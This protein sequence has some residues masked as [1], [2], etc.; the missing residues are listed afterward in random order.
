TAPGLVWFHGGGWVL[1]SLASAHRV[2]GALAKRAGVVVVSIDYRLAPEYPFP[3]G[4][5]DAIAATRWILETAPSLGIDPRAV[6]VGGDSAGGNL[7]A[8]AAQALRSEPRRPAFQLL[9]Y[10]ATELTRSHESH[11]LFAEDYILSK[12]AMDWYLGHYLPDPESASDPAA[13]PFFATDLSGLPPALVLTAGF[14]P[15]RDE[16]RAYADKMRAAGVEVEHACAAGLVHGFLAMTGSIGEA[17]RALDLAALRL[18]T[19][20]ERTTQTQ[21]R[22]P[23]RAAV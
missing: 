14:D 12:R 5:L 20:L 6:A 16:G 13:S 22:G 19:A 3:A 18:R 23:T 1:G 15:L 9:V 21:P 7:A 17:G 8:L 10:P 11:R 4:A 2:C